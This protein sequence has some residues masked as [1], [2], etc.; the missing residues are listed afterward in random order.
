MGELMRKLVILARTAKQINNFIIENKLNSNEIIK[1][2]THSIINN[3][4]NSFNYTCLHGFKALPLLFVDD[5]GYDLPL[6]YK[7]FLKSGKHFQIEQNQIN[8]YIQDI[9]RMSVKDL[10]FN[11]FLIVEP[12]LKNYRT[13]KFPKYNKLSAIQIARQ[14]EWLTGQVITAGSYNELF[15]KYKHEWKNWLKE[16]ELIKWWEDEHG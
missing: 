11:L 5:S 10:L 7:A 2:S 9:E 3:V 6:S 12:H 13:H 16:N 8:L 14:Y 15:L 4:N 1:I